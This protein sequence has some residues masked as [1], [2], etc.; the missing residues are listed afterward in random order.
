MVNTQNTNTNSYSDAITQKIQ[1]TFITAATI[2]CDQYSTI[3]LSVDMSIL[4]ATNLSIDS[5]NDRL[6]LLPDWASKA[7]LEELLKERYPERYL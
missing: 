6:I 3:E 1:E 5:L 4:N 2:K 7:D